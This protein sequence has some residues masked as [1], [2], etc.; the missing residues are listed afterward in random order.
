MGGFRH[1]RIAEMIHRE[2][3][4]RLRN[5]I[6]DHRL[7]PIS[8]THVAVTRDLSRAT[9]Q[10]CPLGGGDVGEDLRDAVN[11]AA[12]AL[13]GPIGRVLRLR[14]SP[15]LVFEIDTHTDRAMYVSKLLDDTRAE[16]EG[17]DPADDAADADGE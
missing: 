5:D 9:V 10:Y 14:H 3:A 8:I 2:I 4:Q 1:E 7:V 11:D 15:E 17:R 12:R 16:R 6:K 13:R